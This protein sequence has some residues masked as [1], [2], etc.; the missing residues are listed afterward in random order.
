MN[1][2]PGPSDVS[3]TP[4]LPMV[5][6][7]DELRVLVDP[8]AVGQ[9]LLP[10]SGQFHLRQQLQGKVHADPATTVLATPGISDPEPTPP[11]PDPITPSQRFAPPLLVQL[12]PTSTAEQ[13]PAPPTIPS[14]F[15]WTSPSPTRPVHRPLAIWNEL[16]ERLKRAP[17]FQDPRGATDIQRLCERVANQ[18]DLLPLPRR[19]EVRGERL[20]V[21][22][23]DHSRRMYPFLEDQSLVL[24]NLQSTYPGTGM[25]TLGGKRPAQLRQI[26][27][28]NASPQKSAANVPPGSHV[29][30]LGDVGVLD[31]TMSTAG[32]WLSWG[33]WLRR[34]GCECTVLFPGEGCHVPP[35][36]SRIFHVVPWCSG[37]WRDTTPEQTLQEVD[38][39]FRIA[40][41]AIGIERRLLRTLRLLLG[42]RDASVESLF[43]QDPRLANDSPVAATLHREPLRKLQQQF[44]NQPEQLRKRVLDAI[45]QQRARQPELAELWLFVVLSLSE[46]SRQLLTQDDRDDAL[47]ML[48]WFNQKLQQDCQT[49]EYTESLRA[50][51]RNIA[52]GIGDRALTGDS[53][54]A[55]KLRA[56]Y[57]NLYPE[58]GEVPGTHPKELKVD[59]EPG[60]VLLRAQPDAQR[61]LL[62][63]LP[64]KN[65]GE[66]PPPVDFPVCG[67]LKAN[68]PH[69]SVQHDQRGKP[70]KVT[71]AGL[72]IQWKPGQTLRIDSN[73]ETAVLQ[74]P[75]RPAWA[76]DCGVDEY[77]QF[78]DL[79]IRNIVQRWRWIPPGR[80]WMGAGKD[81]SEAFPHE[82]PRHLVTLTRGFWMMDTPCTQE[83]WWAVMSD[84]WLR[85]NPSYH[86]GNMRPVERVN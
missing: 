47:N 62:H 5:Y 46:Q 48:L 40:A 76:S 85:R 65:P 73:H 86:R 7:G 15:Q 71:P 51:A 8:K 22:V 60:W 64:E 32:S 67:A 72:E 74:W 50:W 35:V 3:R 6:Y 49:H 80:F 70:L 45:R 43:W 83:L 39:L 54:L 25:L 12:L 9:P 53:D 23:C 38:R 31:R 78:A 37:T 28:P 84:D 4:K 26:E 68:H 56:L 33:Q 16:W 66:L 17:G 61:L 29:L 18:A 30:V 34:Q 63:W 55:V 59:Q 19:H 2:H 52:A 77:G 24:Q 82:R 44:D 1:N 20:L 58:R 69:V 10:G 57:R 42:I 41:P 81:D 79:T 21:V 14:N 75:E 11:P 36:L 27:R 13:Q